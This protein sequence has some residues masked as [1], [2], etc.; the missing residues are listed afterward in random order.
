[1][2]FRF[3]RPAR[4]T[5]AGVILAATWGGILAAWAAFDMAPWVGAALLAFTLPAAWDFAA[6]RVAWITV[7]DTHLRWRSGRQEAEIALA[8]IER[9]RFERRLD[10]TMRVRLVLEGGRKLALPQDAT[11]PH[12]DLR[13]ALEARGLRCENHPFSLL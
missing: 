2:N 8:R 7:D 6:G 12:E 11:P 3:E 13:K 10:L 9:V 5:R 4:T 1:M